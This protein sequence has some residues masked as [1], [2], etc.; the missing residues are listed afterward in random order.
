MTH[1]EK[2]ICFLSPYH[3]PVPNSPK[4]GKFHDSAKNSHR[5]LWSLGM[6]LVY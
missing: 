1:G 4:T 2:K 5:K 3:R 6:I